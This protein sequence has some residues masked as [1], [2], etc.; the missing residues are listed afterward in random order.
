ME[1][2]K[3]RLNTKIEPYNE[4]SKKLNVE[5]GNFATLVANG[6]LANFVQV[7]KQFDYKAIKNL[8]KTGL[9]PVQISPHAPQTCA[10][11]IPPLRQI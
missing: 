10:S 5:D 6:R 8:S 11:T 2:D 9:E 7:P 1:P 4:G 3:S